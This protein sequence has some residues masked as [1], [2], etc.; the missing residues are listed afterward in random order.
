MPPLAMPYPFSCVRRDHHGGD[1]VGPSGKLLSRSPTGL[2]GPQPKHM[3]SGLNRSWML[4]SSVP[5]RSVTSPPVVPATVVDA[6]EPG[7]RQQRRRRPERALL[8]H[9]RTVDA[10]VDH[11]HELR[12][13]AS[14]ADRAVTRSLAQRVDGAVMRAAPPL[15][16]LRAPA[17]WDW[18]VACP[19]I[20][21]PSSA[22]LDASPDAIVFDHRVLL[23]FAHRHMCD[24]APNDQRPEVPAAR[25]HPVYVALGPGDR[26]TRAGHRDR[27]GASRS[28]GGPGEEP[29]GRHRKQLA[30]DWSSHTGRAA[31]PASATSRAIHTGRSSPARQAPPRG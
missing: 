18:S 23:A 15:P 4:S 20:R 30:R 11:L 31:D 10:L 26:T 22:D 2:A 13:R 28:I 21:W 9:H 1:D 27:G 14:A 16:R 7:A 29:L 6:S 3:P 12:P 8:V 25:S 17:S 24:G 19:V 5:C